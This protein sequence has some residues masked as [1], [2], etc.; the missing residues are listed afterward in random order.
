[1]S[2][3]GLVI[4]CSFSE[5]DGSLSADQQLLPII[6]IEHLTNLSSTQLHSPIAMGLKVV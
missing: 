6:Y 2:Y 1:M 5:K 3:T 4:S